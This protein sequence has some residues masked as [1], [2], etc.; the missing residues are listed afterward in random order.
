MYLVTED[1]S[2]WRALSEGDDKWQSV[3]YMGGVLQITVMIHFT[4]DVL[5]ILPNDLEIKWHKW[6]LHVTTS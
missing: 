6:K 4:S 2:Q 3:F 5:N 1:M